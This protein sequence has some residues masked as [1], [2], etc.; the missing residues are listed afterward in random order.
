MGTKKKVKEYYPDALERFGH[1]LEI[2]RNNGNK[3]IQKT[4]VN[5]FGLQK[6]IMALPKEDREKIEKFWGLT[7]GVN[8][9]LRMTQPNIK[10]VAYHTMCRDAHLAVDKLFCLDF[11]RMYDENYDS[12][13]RLINSK[14]IK[15]ENTQ[16]N[17]LENVRY[18]IAFSI[19]FEN[20]PKMNYDRDLMNVETRIDKTH[21]VDEY[22]ALKEIH[23]ALRNFPENVVNVALVKSIFEMMDY[24]DCLAIRKNFKIDISQNICPAE[25][26]FFRETISIKKFLSEIKIEEFENFGQLRAFKERVFQH[27]S[28]DVTCGLVFGEDVDIVPFFTEVSKFDEDWSKIENFKTGQKTLRTT[29][30]VQTLDV[31]TIGGLEFTDP[32]EIV[33]LYLS[34][35]VIM[36]KAKC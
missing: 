31:Y 1:Y 34:H 36:S 2:K 13:I 27:G 14:V 9:S 7:G 28:W 20:G 12:Q 18:L 24:K 15:D 3:D 30:G 11:V 10:D 5:Y 32:Y 23:T 33:S 16:N 8:H 26:L 25:I 19:V 22:E 29:E 21:N 17:P 35:D 4:R 6:A